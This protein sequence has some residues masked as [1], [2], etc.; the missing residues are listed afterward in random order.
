[1]SRLPDTLRLVYHRDGSYPRA[2]PLKEA[3]ANLDLPK[4]NADRPFVYLNMVQTL[5]GQAVLEGTAFAIGTAVDH[6][7]FRQL[8]VHADAVLYGAGTLRKDDVIV[9]THEALQERR[10]AR[11]QP[12]NPLAVV[13]S[14]TCEFEDAVFGKKFFSRTDF[15][16]L[17]I[18]TQRA[19]PSRVDRIKAAGVPVE[20]VAADDSGEVDMQ[21]LTRHLAARGVKRLLTEGGP[22]LNVPM[23]RHG[24]IDQMFLTV[25][26]RIG[27]EAGEP[28]IFA[29][30]IGDRPLALISALHFIDPQGPGELYFRFEFLPHA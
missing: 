28:R 15:D 9:T 25:S 27:G 18:T 1:M 21:A 23:A 5:D 24:L 10:R 6:H 17:I 7:L 29:A 13:V 30:P 16:K 4:G 11:G 22:T 12:A 8:R 2:V 19:S 26:L 14:G 3:Y 20:I